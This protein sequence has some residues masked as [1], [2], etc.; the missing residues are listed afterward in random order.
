MR[1]S[2]SALAAVVVLSGAMAGVGSRRA[3]A[4]EGG[5]AL[6]AFAEGVEAYEGGDFG[7]EI[8]QAPGAENDFGN[9]AQNKG[10][11]GELSDQM[12]SLRIGSAQIAVKCRLFHL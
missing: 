4:A 6:V 3:F 5:D 10:L 9:A 11:H 12:N 8:G 1:L 7:A 2:V